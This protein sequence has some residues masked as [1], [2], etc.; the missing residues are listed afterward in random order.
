MP[1]P[2]AHLRLVEEGARTILALEG[3]LNAAGAGRLWRPA[4]LAATRARGRPLVLDLRDVS[5]CDTGGAT[6]LAAIEAAHG[7][8]DEMLGDTERIAR[9][10]QRAHDAIAQAPAAQAPRRPSLRA[11]LAVLLEGSAQGVAF[12]GEAALALLALPRRRRMFRTIELARH[13]DQAGTRSLPLLL[14]LG[15]LMGLILAFQSAIPMRRFGADLYV[16]NLVAISLLRE[17]GPLLAAVI[18]A[19]RTGSAFAAELGTM[20]VNEE[21]DAL[22]TMG[23]HPMTMLVLPRLAAVMLVIPA[24]TMVLE[25]AGLAGM[26]TVMTGFG[27]S[28]SAI[29]RQVQAATTLGD[30][31]GGLAKSVVFGM[32]VAAIGCRTGMTAGMGPRAVGQAATA[33]VVGGIVATIVL[34][35]FFALLFYRLGL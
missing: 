6:L 23:L 13:A 3:R 17:L 27:F 28:L 8:I 32:T 22:S 19:G 34:D 18:L 11:R 21:L 20:K 24:M 25:I 4:M 1:I 26:A 29:S 2:P 15:Y 30:L 14:M 10:R 16:A 9:L 7:G 12:L 5:F 35:G 33:A 31:L